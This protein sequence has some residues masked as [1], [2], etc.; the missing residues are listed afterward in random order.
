MSAV[1]LCQHTPPHR[2]LRLL[3]LCP[4]APNPRRLGV[5]TRDPPTLTAQ[6]RLLQDR[7]PASR[8]SQLLPRPSLLACTAPS[9]RVRSRWPRPAQRHNLDVDSRYCGG[10]GRQRGSGKI[11]IG[12]CTP[13]HS[14]NLALCP[15]TPTPGPGKARRPAPHAPVP[16]HVCGLLILFLVFLKNRVSGFV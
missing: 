2:L 11:L 10:R 6:P 1:C 13:P 5:C 15:A 3:S 16:Y 14:I 7:P 12:D 8:A 4:S 9:A